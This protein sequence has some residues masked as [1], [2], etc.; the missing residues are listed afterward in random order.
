M[1]VHDTGGDNNG[2]DMWDKVLI[3]VFKYISILTASITF[4]QI[5][6]VYSYCIKLHYFDRS[7]V[8]S[9]HFSYY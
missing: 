5:E 2:V 1:L 6:H 8:L 3:H 9:V 4:K 7:A